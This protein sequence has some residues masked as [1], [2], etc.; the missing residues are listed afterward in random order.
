MPTSRTGL[1]SFDIFENCVANQLVG[2]EPEC[3]LKIAS[4]QDLSQ[5]IIRAISK[6]CTTLGVMY[7]Y[8]IQKRPSFLGGADRR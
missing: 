6:L 7:G 1:Q 3:R 8:Q 2:A 5:Y 4:N